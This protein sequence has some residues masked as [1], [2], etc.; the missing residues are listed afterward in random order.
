MNRREV[1]VILNNYSI[2]GKVS[3]AGASWEVEFDNEKTYKRFK[4]AAKKCGET[5]A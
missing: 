3:G 5:N 4:S 2:I 1:C